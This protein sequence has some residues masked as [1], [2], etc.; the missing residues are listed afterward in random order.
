MILLIKTHNIDFKW[1]TT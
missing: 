1:N